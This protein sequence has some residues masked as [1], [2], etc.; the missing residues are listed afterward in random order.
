MEIGAGIH[1]QGHIQQSLGGC[2]CIS[3]FP[4]PLVP[5]YPH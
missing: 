3:A 1:N 5:I 4:T 2:P